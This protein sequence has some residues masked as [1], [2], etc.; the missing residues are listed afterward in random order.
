MIPPNSVLA[1]YLTLYGE[2]SVLQIDLIHVC[3]EDNGAARC[4]S[5]G[6][7]VGSSTHP[8]HGCWASTQSVPAQCW[9]DSA[10]RHFKERC[11]SSLSQAGSHP[12]FAFSSSRPATGN[13][14]TQGT[15]AYR[16]FSRGPL[17]CCGTK[18]LADR[19]GSLGASGSHFLAQGCWTRILVCEVGLRGDDTT[20]S[21][22][23]S[24]VSWRL[25]FLPTLGRRLQP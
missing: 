16:D 22:H 2:S 23:H 25:G 4:P 8:A 6:T 11:R 21:S 9:G 7:L 18:E 12:P 20:P 24:S 3:L 19:Y 13:R 1:R 14:V 10:P 17:V 5:V 15:S